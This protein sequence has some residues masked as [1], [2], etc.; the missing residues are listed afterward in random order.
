MMLM[1]DGVKRV[2]FG[3]TRVSTEEQTF[4]ASLENQRIAIQKYAN[5]NDI[6][7]IGWYTDAGISA[8]TAHRP[9]LQK[10][11]AD[12]AKRKGRIDHVVVYNV[13]RI[14][15][16][17]TSFF[18]DIGFILAKCGVTLRSTQEVIDESPTGRFMLNIALSVHQLDNDIKS[19]TVKDDMAL[20]ASYGWWMSQAPIGLKLKPIVTGELTNDGKKK[21]HNTLE[22]DET[23]DAGKK[24]QFLL[25]RFSEGDIAPMELVNLAHKMG[26][27]GKNGKPIT[28]NTMLGILRQSVYAGYNTSKKLLDGKPTKIKDFD[29]L[30][31][32]DTYNKNQRILSGKHC[33]L[34]P[35][36]SEL[37]PLRKLLICE[38]CGTLIRSS[39]PRSGSGKASPRY[40]C[41]TKG[42]GSIPIEEMHQL[43]VDFLEE[44]TPSEGVIKLFKEIVKRTAAKKLGDTTRELAKC[45]E[46]ISDIDKKLIE[47]VDAMLEGRI[48]IDEKNRYSEALETKRQDLRREIDKL[49]QSQDLNEA[50][51]DYV[52]NFMTKPAKLWKD[53]DLETKQ[54]FQKML[55]PKGL[56]FDIKNKI[57]GT[58]DLSPLFSVIDNKKESCDGSNSEMVIPKGVEPLIFWMRTRRPGPLDDGTTRII[59]AKIPHNYNIFLEKCIK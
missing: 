12:I 1:N 26:V 15:R 22:I 54:A 14:S 23:N 31:D 35:S 21:H 45:R 24:I 27:N 6:E 36:N 5:Q 16:D 42:H 10:M 33:P 20:L 55:F 59:L 30:I 51:I 13:S 40:H 18:N 53:A 41:T 9:E 52:C 34:V 19:K 7:I 39:A 46:A 49:E 57:F 3:Y 47:A 25:N 48:G 43:F 28:L 44:I 8:K 58:D 29:G 37:Y 11:L 2:A 56:H 50:T 32:I 38:D 4:G 17:M